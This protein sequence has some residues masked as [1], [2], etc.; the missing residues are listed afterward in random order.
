[1]RSGAKRRSTSVPVVIIFSLFIS[2]LLFVAGG[3]KGHAAGCTPVVPTDQKFGATI[4]VADDVLVS[5]TTLSGAIDATGCDVGVYIG[6]NVTAYVVSAFVHDANQAGVFNDGGN[7]TIS[8][9]I[10]Y[11]TGNHSGTTFSPNGVQTGLDVYYSCSGM[12]SIYDNTIDEYQK[13]GIVAR[14]LGS[15]PRFLSIKDNTVKGLGPVGFIAQNGI[16][17]GFGSGSCRSTLSSS[18]VDQVTGNT[19]SDNHYTQKAQK[20]V[21]STGILADA[22]VGSSSGQLTSTLKSSNTVSNNQANVVVL[23]G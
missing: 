2:T 16:E 3:V 21:T 17:V 18:N 20:G 4:M 6:P 23:V 8:G 15:A 19:V 13:G 7:L 14:S 5:G 22:V 12:G 11:N 9:S 1:M 10:I